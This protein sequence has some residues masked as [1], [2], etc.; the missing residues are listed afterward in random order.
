MKSRQEFMAEIEFESRKRS[1]KGC[2]DITVTMNGKGNRVNIYFR[3]GK[4]ENFP[5]GVMFGVYKNR[6]VFEPNKTDGYTIT[7]PKTN[8]IDYGVL[9]ATVAD[10]EKYRVWIG[11]YELKWDEFYGFWYIERA[12]G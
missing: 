6:M 9:S 8:R 3:N 1:G 4:K 7:T 5:D 2:S 12:E 11:D 10:A